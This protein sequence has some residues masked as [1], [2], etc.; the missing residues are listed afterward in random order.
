MSVL[1][2]LS[3]KLFSSEKKIWHQISLFRFLYYV[4]SKYQKNRGVRA[5]YLNITFS[6]KQGPCPEFVLGLGKSAD[7]G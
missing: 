6:T 3:S 5:M 7:S 4:D 1:G 2:Q